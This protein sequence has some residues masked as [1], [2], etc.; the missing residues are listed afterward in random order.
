MFRAC[1]NLI[2]VTVI[3]VVQVAA[4]SPSVLLDGAD[5]PPP[6]PTRKVRRDLEQEIR[7]LQQ[8][9][10]TTKLQLERALNASADD[11]EEETL[12]VEAAVTWEEVASLLP[13]DY[14]GEID[15][16]L[17]MTSGAIAPRKAASRSESI[18][19]EGCTKTLAA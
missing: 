12:P 13:T 2:L 10:D 7:E 8:E 17:A 4:C 3:A 14:T 19:G 6:P 15:W 5:K 9:L 11:L 1:I 16:M 18:T